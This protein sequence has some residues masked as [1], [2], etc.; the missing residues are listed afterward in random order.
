MSEQR[1]LLSVA[2]SRITLTD[3]SILEQSVKVT[4][5]VQEPASRRSDITVN[6]LALER[7]G[8]DESEDGSAVQNYVLRLNV[9]VEPSDDS[10]FYDCGI[11]IMGL[12][13]VLD[14]SLSDESIRHAIG[15]RGVQELYDTARVCFAQATSNGRYGTLLLPSI[16]IV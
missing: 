7:L 8:G 16:D 5:K 10:N 15:T 13:A 2:L 4:E 3:Y 14:A 6:I 11:D 12:F 9:T 1:E